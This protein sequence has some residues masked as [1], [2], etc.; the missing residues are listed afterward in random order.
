MSSAPTATKGHTLCR[1]RKNQSI[2]N[3]L[4]V[5]K[6]CLFSTTEQVYTLNR[7]G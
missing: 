7:L 6:L 4:I 1:P 3:C 2:L 5:R